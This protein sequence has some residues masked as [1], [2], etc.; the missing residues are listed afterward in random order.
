MDMARPQRV[1]SFLED[2][3]MF[4]W[5]KRRK[6]ARML[7]EPFPQEYVSLLEREVAVCRAVPPELR[8]KLHDDLR[9]FISEVTWEGCGGQSVTEEMKVLIA[10]QACMLTLGRSLDDLA[11]VRSILVYPEA[12]FAPADEVDDAGV[13]TEGEEDR[14]GEA[15]ETG[16]VVLSWADLRQDARRR[17]GRNLVLHE[18]AH[19]LDMNDG[20]A[21]GMPR[22]DEISL[23]KR[24]REVMST[25][26]EALGR[27]A[28]RGKAGRRS[29]VLDP[30][31]AEDESE[32]FSV[33]VE[34]FFEKG[35]LLKETHPGLY[36]LLRD[37]FH[38]DPANWGVES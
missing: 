11:I 32:F 13:V 18:L 14:E 23:R 28:Q 26:F 20:E 21:N 17:D 31:G 6:R 1:N 4:S 19:Q 36:G 22:I 27:M 5:L 37:Y 2:C 7:T 16:I 29:G 35:A 15:W 3:L 34:A 8:S 24:W 12:Y 10:G 38:L 9:V 30:Y 25:E 33:C